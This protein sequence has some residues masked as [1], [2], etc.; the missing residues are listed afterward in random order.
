MANGLNEQSVELGWPVS[1]SLPGPLRR[2]L[3]LGDRTFQLVTGLFALAL[4]AVL[5]SIV[6]VLALESSGSIR[7]FGWGFL[8][9]SAWDPVFR[10]FGALPF[11]YGTVVSSIL[12]LLQAVPLSIGTAIFLSELAPGWVRG[13]VSFLV[14][15]LAT[16]PSVVY[17]LWAIF[18]LIP[19]VRTVVAPSLS[20]VLGFLPLFQGPIYGVGM[21]T[22]SMI[23][24]V[25]VVPYITSVAH[26]VFQAVPQ[27]QR[28]AALALGA[29]K[30]EMVRMAVVP[31]GRTGLIGAIMLGLGRAIGETM[32]V[33]MVIGNRA[34]ITASL[35]A[36]ASTMA[37]VI[38]NEFSE[39]TYDLYVQALVEVGLVLL[40]VTVVINAFARLLVWSVAGPTGVARGA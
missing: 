16:I 21:L 6:V 17:G 23:L 5:A 13:P 31:F 24:A 10:K 1:K 3:N 30:W 32:A 14:E 11:I 7:W 40:I 4:V 19:W 20:T 34:E 8:Y 39:A 37:S 36:P 18:V 29:T 27:S 12:A 33:T 25:M 38:A 2:R 9:S 28:E 22:A 35:F 15:L 26:E